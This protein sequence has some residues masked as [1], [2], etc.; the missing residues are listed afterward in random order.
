MTQISQPTPA[1]VENLVAF[2]GHHKVGSSALQRFLALNARSLLKEGILYPAIDM[3]GVLKLYADPIVSTDADFRPG[4]NVVEPHNALAFALFAQA[5]GPDV[6]DFIGDIPSPADIFA[7]MQEQVN[8]F[9]PHSVL[10]VSEVLSRSADVAPDIAMQIRDA[11]PH[12]HVRILVTL[13]NPAHYLPSFHAQLI[14]LGARV[15]PLRAGMLEQYLETVHVRYDHLV[16]P[17]A[18]AFGKEA[19]SVATY[20]DV[21]QRGGAISDFFAR[22]ALKRPSDLAEVGQVNPS[23]PYAVLEIQRQANHVLPRNLIR[24]LRVFLRSQAVGALLPPSRTIEMFGPGQR[25]VLAKRFG[26]VSSGMRAG[27]GYRL[28]DAEWD[29][30]TPSPLT[31]KEAVTLALECLP[32]ADGY[33]A[34]PVA[35]KSFLATIRFEQIS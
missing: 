22:G 1:S 12:R 23:L 6:P 33:D 21:V 20:D 3:Y 34:L 11:I 4:L 13:R 24:R 18:D 32:K 10:M 28:D 35:L 7:A 30:E 25:A 8:S 14:K 29:I 9:Q 17:W 27:L 16:K 15:P 5:G 2:V 31:E 19:V 26:V